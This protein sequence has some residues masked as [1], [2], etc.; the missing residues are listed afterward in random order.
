MFKNLFIFA[1]CN[2]KRIKCHEKNNN[3]YRQNDGR[4]GRM[5]CTC[6]DIKLLH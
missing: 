5:S 2:K 3:N 6:S 1:L 4:H